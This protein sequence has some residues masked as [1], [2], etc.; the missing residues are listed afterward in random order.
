MFGIQRLHE[1]VSQGER[2]LC[3]AGE[4]IIVTCKQFIAVRNKPTTC[5]WS[6]SDENEPTRTPIKQR[7]PMTEKVCRWGIMGT[8]GIARKNWK[9]IRLSGN[10]AGGCR[11]QPQ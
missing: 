8:A 5:A 6:S 3:R 4:K 7:W 2:A 11:S 10:A 1:L 9:A